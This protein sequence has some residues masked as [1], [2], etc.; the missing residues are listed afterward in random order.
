MLLHFLFLFGEVGISL[1]PLGL[2]PPE[3]PAKLLFIVELALAYFKH[4]RPLFALFLLVIIGVTIHV[5]FFEGLLHFSDFAFLLI[6][7]VLS[8]VFIFSLFFLL[9]LVGCLFADIL[10]FLLGYWLWLRLFITVGLIW[11]ME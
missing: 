10:Y 1:L 11:V 6:F 4:I 3:M 2:P 5:E 9:F 8:F 7:F